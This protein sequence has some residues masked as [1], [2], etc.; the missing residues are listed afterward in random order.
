MNILCFLL[1][2]APVSTCNNTFG[3][4]KYLV[5]DVGD[6]LITPNDCFRLSTDSVLFNVSMDYLYLEEC[7]QKLYTADYADM[8]YGSMLYALKL[9]RSW[10]VLW[11]IKSEYYPTFKI[12]RLQDGKCNRVS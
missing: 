7:K 4:F 9:W 11:E 8:Q 3:C 2:L 12:Y 5:V 1:F 6:N 10:I